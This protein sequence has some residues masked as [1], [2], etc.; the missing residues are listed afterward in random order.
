[1]N[2]EK[3]LCLRMEEIKQGLKAIIEGSGL[4]CYIIEPILKDIYNQVK[5]GKK[6]EVEAIKQAYEAPAENEG[7]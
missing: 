4:P 6:A 1:M 2:N 3:P 5:E 7:G